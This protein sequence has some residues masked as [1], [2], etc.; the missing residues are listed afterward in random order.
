[1][2]NNPPITYRTFTGFGEATHKAVLASIGNLRRFCINPND[3]LVRL[4][5][6]SKLLKLPNELL[7]KLRTLLMELGEIKIFFAWLSHTDA[8]RLLRK[9]RSFATWL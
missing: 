2:A 1:M 5:G 9:R 4:L 6:P 3:Y 7:L 8:F